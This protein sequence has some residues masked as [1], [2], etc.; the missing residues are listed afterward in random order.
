MK[1]SDTVY[2]YKNTNNTVSCLQTTD[3]NNYSE[4][5]PQQC[6]FKE[7]NFLVVQFPKNCLFI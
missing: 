4:L 6:E 1:Y 7:N 5:K 3:M 2:K